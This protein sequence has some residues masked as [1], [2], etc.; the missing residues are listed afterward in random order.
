MDKTKEN[1][2]KTNNPIPKESLPVL[3][4][5]FKMENKKIQKKHDTTPSRI[6][7]STINTQILWPGS[8]N[9]KIKPKFL[10]QIDTKYVTF[11][12][13]NA[14]LEWNYEVFNDNQVVKDSSI[15]SISDDEVNAGKENQPCCVELKPKNE[16][17]DPLSTVTPI[18]KAY[19]EPNRIKNIKRSLKR[20]H[21]REL[22]G[23]S[24]KNNEDKVRRR[25]QFSQHLEEDWMH[26]AEFWERS[27]MRCLNKDYTLDI[28]NHLLA[29]EKKPQGIP[30]TSSI[31]R[32][33]VINWLLKVH[34]AD[35][36]PSTV[37]S[38]CWYLDSI[39][40]TGRVQL[41]K[42]QL[43][44]AACYWIAQ[45]LYGPVKP[46]SRLVKCAN[47]AFTTKHLMNAEKIVLMRLKFPPQPV[48]IQDYISYI[49][50]YCAQSNGEKIAQAATFLSMCGLMVDKTLCNE[51]PSV[52]AV[53]AVRNALLLLKENDLI[54]RLQ[55]C[56]VFNAAERKATKLS[57][58]CSILRAAVRIV[59]SAGYEYK[60]LLEHYG[61]A[62]NYIAQKIVDAVQEL[63]F[64][65]EGNINK[66]K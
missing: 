19:L 53:A 15:I 36:N 51:Y 57:L 45:K 16:L 49:S 6:P 40:G 55:L 66:K 10:M 29:V 65:D 48:V 3:S 44:A 52:I 4:R 39:L 37:Q 50:W 2:N 42:L 11:R 54:S 33:C 5:D 8:S 38:A 12:K 35:G 9:V 62:P 59:S 32:A 24:P 30:S 20:P 63:F 14:D 56:P 25:L 28:F 1:I 13:R 41:E 23:L 27:Y 21:S 43:V 58:T 64:V 31:T 61:T 22:Q 34:G 17:C 18:L 26:K 47:K 60:T 7:L 46:A